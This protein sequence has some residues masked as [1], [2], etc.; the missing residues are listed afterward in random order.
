MALVLAE[1]VV[2][3]PAKIRSRMAEGAAIRELAADEVPAWLA[4]RLAGER[5][6]AVF[7]S[8][9]GAVAC[10]AGGGRI[11]VRAPKI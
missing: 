9:W 7:Q 2:D 4:Q 1:A 3:L 6:E 8:R 10:T 5:V 11:V